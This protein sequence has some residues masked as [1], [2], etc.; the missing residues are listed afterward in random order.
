[1]TLPRLIVVGGSGL[2]GGALRKVAAAAGRDVIGTGNS[3]AGAGLLQFDMRQAPLRS[4]VPDLGP[5]DVVY[6]LA[7]YI[8]PA[9]I[10]ANPEA[11][12]ELNLHASRRLADEALA[13]GARLVFMSTDLVF[14]GETGGYTETATPRPLN[15][16]GRLKVEMEQHVLPKGGIVART[17]WNVA[18]VKGVHCAVAQCYDALLKP[19]ARMA[20]DNLIS[21]S[22]VEDTARGLLALARSGP[23][24]HNIYH[25]VSSPGVGRADLAATIKATSRYGAAMAYQVIKFAELPYTEPRPVRSFLASERQAEL[26][27]SF[28][29]PDPVIRKKVAL[30]DTWRDAES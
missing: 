4:V 13:A 7:A 10:F 6:L 20:G 16:Y 9:W 8:A 23:L 25:L 14:D 21:I 17:G 15:L 30:L 18:W 3:R 5:N 2:I 12:R 1:M 27:V 19:G 22:D 26:G 11:A 29:P 28:A 24:Q